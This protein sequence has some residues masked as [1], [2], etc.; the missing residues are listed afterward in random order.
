MNPLLSV[1]HLKVSFRHAFKTVDAVRDVSFDVY[2]GDTIG[3]VGESGCGKSVMVKALLNLFSSPSAKIE[4]GEVFYEHQDLLSLSERELRK[5]RG[6]EIGMIFQDPMT[7]LNPTMR[8]G[9]QIIESLL[10]HEPH[11][12]HQE[13]HAR[14]LSLLSLVGIPEPALRVMQYPHELSGGMRQRVMIALALAPSPRLLIADEPTTA[15]DVTIQAQILQLLKEIQQKTHTSILFI[16]HDLSVVA[17]FCNKVMVMYA[18]KIV[19]TATV[20]M[21]FKNPKHPYTQRLLE[22]IPRLDLPN[23]AALHPIL[24]APPD[25]SFT[26]EGCSFAPRCHKLLNI[27]IQQSPPL[28]DVEGRT[29]ACWHYDPRCVEVHT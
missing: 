21:L 27:C 2:P 19:E 5:I 13:A 15:L 24:G 16:T 29:C 23:E 3:I 28:F 8:V 18:G 17:G 9:K 4:G 11:I 26:L 14:A 20:D 1:K 22:S 6:K 7:S 25:L 10:K 12:S